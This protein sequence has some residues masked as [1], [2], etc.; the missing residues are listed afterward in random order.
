MAEKSL[1]PG[2]TIS[3]S[4]NPSASVLEATAYIPVDTAELCQAC[5]SEAAVSGAATLAPRKDDQ[6]GPAPS[7]AGPVKV[8]HSTGA[9]RLGAPVSSV[10]GA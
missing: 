1:G 4:A 3:L 5:R 2:T 9:S 7:E 8:A 6:F 10:T